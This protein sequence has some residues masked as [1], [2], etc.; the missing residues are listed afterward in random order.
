[1]TETWT[2]QRCEVFHVT[3][4]CTICRRPSKLSSLSIMTS[5]D[6]SHE[7]SHCHSHSRNLY[8]SLGAIYLLPLL[9]AL[10]FSHICYNLRPLYSVVGPISFWPS[11]PSCMHH[12]SSLRKLFKRLCVG[13]RGFS[14]MWWYRLS[15]QKWIQRTNISWIRGITLA[16][17]N[18]NKVFIMDAAAIFDLAMTS[19][20]AGWQAR[21]SVIFHV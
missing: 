3:P 5:F 8:R 14:I 18:T 7:H 20:V 9:A 13:L 19:F 1:M 10:G 4:A 12:M 6:L 2:I 21:N 11:S 17:Y 15:I 16:N